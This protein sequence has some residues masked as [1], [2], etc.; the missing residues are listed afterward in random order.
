MDRTG[1]DECVNVV[2]QALATN[3][4][5]FKVTQAQLQLRG[6]SREFVLLPLA[7]RYVQDLC[8]R[9]Q[10]DGLVV[11]KAFDSDMLL[12]R[13]NGTRTV[14]VEEGKKYRVTTITCQNGD[15]DL[16]RNYFTTAKKIPT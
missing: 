1:A 11:P 6:R 12:T 15:I 7:P 9:T 13:T 4:C 3:S 14:K 2:G 8:R 10:V 5:R 16:S